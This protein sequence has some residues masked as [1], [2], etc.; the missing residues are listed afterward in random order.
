[1]LNAF[2]KS[3]KIAAPKLLVL[4]PVL[5]VCRIKIVCALLKHLLKPKL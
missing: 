3:I 1:M 5:K 2:Y 4:K